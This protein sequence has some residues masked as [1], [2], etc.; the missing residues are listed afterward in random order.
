MLGRILR[1]GA[2]LSHS[3]S[4][5]VPRRFVRL[6]GSYITAPRLGRHNVRHHS[7]STAYQ[8]GQ[9]GPGNSSGRGGVDPIEVSHFNALASTWWDAQ[10]PSRLLHL[11]N[12]MRIDFVKHC[13][14]MGGASEAHSDVGAAKEGLGK[15]LN[16]LDV[17]CG[18]G[19]FSEAMARLPTTA[20]VTGLDPSEQVL[21]IA[22]AHAM[23]DPT[24]PGK[25]QYVNS[26]IDDYSPDRQ[27]D[28]ITLFEVVEHV[29]YPAA[30]LETCMRHVRPGGWIVMSTI[31]RTWSSWLTTK[32]LAEDL[33]H[34]VPRGTHDWHKYINEPEMRAFFEKQ[35]GWG[36]QGML[37]MGCL[38]VPGIGWKSLKGSEEFGNYFFGVRRDL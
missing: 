5:M 37:S 8:G 9:G 30:F 12:P 34:I 6:A 18:G 14:S 10:G 2:P 7:S 24:L 21:A 16:V 33:L 28:L 32:L 25:L 22:R 15:G 11:M 4:Q 17:G 38:Y 29:P 13:L 19:I 35:P 23:K 31:A 36:S 26:T 20:K 3:S 1:V 27:F